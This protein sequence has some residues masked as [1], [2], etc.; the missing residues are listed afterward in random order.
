M[1]FGTCD[2]FVQFVGEL[3][4]T[5]ITLDEKNA[6]QTT[7]ESF[8]SNQGV[9]KALDRIGVISRVVIFIFVLNS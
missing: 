5:I 4:P 2:Y 8:D 1:L 7:F 9:T 6:T 3:R